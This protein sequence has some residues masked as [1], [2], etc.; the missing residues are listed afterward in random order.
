MLG[1]FSAL[2]DLFRDSPRE[3]YERA[4]YE[5]EQ[6]ERKRERVESESESEPCGTKV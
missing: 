2:I 1:L 4:C 3:R 5:A 6:E